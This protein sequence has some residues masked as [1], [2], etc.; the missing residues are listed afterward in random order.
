MAPYPL[1]ARELLGYSPHGRQEGGGVVPRRSDCSDE[2]REA[3][4][5]GCHGASGGVVAAH[6]QREGFDERPEAVALPRV[7]R[8]GRRR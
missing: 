6:G 8:V 1:K 3:C 7:V 5:G 2:R 4:E